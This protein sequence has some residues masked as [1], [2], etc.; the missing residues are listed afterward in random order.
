[1]C[2]PVSAGIA[3]V[4]M[5]ASFAG[6]QMQAKT[7][8]ENAARQ[9]AAILNAKAATMR[10]QREARAAEN[11]RQQRLADESF[12]AFDRTAGDTVNALLP[13][14]LD[15]IAARREAEDIAAMESAPMAV[16]AF[17]TPADAPRV[18]KQDAAKRALES[19]MFGKQ[20][21]RARAQLGAFGDAGFAVTQAAREGRLAQGDIGRRAAGS[22]RLLPLDLAAAEVTPQLPAPRSNPLGALLAGAGQVAMSYGAS[23]GLTP[24][25]PSDPTPPLP[26]EKPPAGLVPQLDMLAP[27]AYAGLY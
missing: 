8:A 20:Q 2:D 22:A 14:S 23:R 10:G 15:A 9:E 16:G 12:Q 25:A 7:A 21:A 1:M 3:A 5:L 27:A 6:N 4:G 18:V 26:R 13:S 24:A 17:D 19:L 11:A